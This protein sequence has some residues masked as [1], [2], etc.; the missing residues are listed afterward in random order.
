M[1]RTFEFEGAPGHVS[2][3]TLTLVEQG[4]K[5]TLTAR[6]VFPTPEERDAM[7]RSGME[8]GAR[9]AMDRLAEYLNVMG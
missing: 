7:L 8:G 4:G 2:V 6:S 1:V 5:T 9:E 3:E